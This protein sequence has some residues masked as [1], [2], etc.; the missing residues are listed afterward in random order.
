MS[1]P[2]AMMYLLL[3]QWRER[4]TMYQAFLA[5]ADV[6]EYRRSESVTRVLLIG[7][8]TS[9]GSEK[10]FMERLCNNSN[11]NN[12]TMLQQFHNDIQEQQGN[13]AASEDH[14]HDAAAVRCDVQNI[15]NAWKHPT[16]PLCIHV[17]QGISDN[18]NAGGHGSSRQVLDQIGNFLKKRNSDWT[19]S[20]WV[21]K[22]QVL[23]RKG[24][25]QDRDHG[26]PIQKLNNNRLHVVWLLYSPHESVHVEWARLKDELAIYELPVQI[27]LDTQLL[28]DTYHHEHHQAE[29]SDSGDPITIAEHN[30]QKNFLDNRGFMFPN[31]RALQDQFIIV[32]PDQ[33]LSSSRSSQD[34][35][36][37]AHPQ[38][39]RVLSEDED[40]ELLIRQQERRIRHEATRQLTHLDPKALWASAEVIKTIANIQQT[41]EIICDIA[42]RLGKR[43][44]IIAMAPFMMLPRRYTLGQSGI[45]TLRCLCKIW[46]VPKPME[47]AMLKKTASW[48]LGETQ[49]DIGSAPG[50]ATSVSLPR[51]A[52]PHESTSPTPALSLADGRYLHFSVRVAGVILYCKARHPKGWIQDGFL[53]TDYMLEFNSFY[54]AYQNQFDELT[55]NTTHYGNSFQFLHSLFASS[56]HKLAGANLKQQLQ[57]SLEDFFVDVLNRTDFSSDDLVQ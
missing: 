42:S 43:G 27:V 28:P 17:S 15:N 53:S 4:K 24:W 51:A 9:S 41:V 46:E 37:L 56:D 12:S 33:T 49:N 7:S 29:Y 30:L 23:L 11:S 14:D 36:S 45:F 25:F 48:E 13:P 50:R 26:R 55:K 16:L 22:W 47:A 44:T 39:E 57:T 6:E 8:P 52:A 1:G 31:V 32:P 20:S 38:Q 40:A 10:N 19:S 21:A 5:A 18:M 34:Y 2:A 54:S 3:L 35:N